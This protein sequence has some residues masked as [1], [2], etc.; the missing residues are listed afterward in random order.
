[1]EYPMK[2]I[3]IAPDSSIEELA[4]LALS[5]HNAACRMPVAIKSRDSA[6]ILIED[7]EFILSAMECKPLERM[8]TGDCVR[9]IHIVEGRHCGATMFASAIVN[10][11]GQRVAAIGIIDTLGLLSLE[12][13]VADSELVDSQL[14]G[15]RPRK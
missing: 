2:P 5:V 7:G 10:G 13:F 4:M 11:L 3:R 8:F 6:G 9:R 1:M 15:L 12:R 14:G